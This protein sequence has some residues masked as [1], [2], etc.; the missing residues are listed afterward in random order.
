MQVEEEENNAV[1]GWD[2]GHGNDDDAQDDFVEMDIEAAAE[3]DSES[4]SFSDTCLPEREQ[5]LVNGTS[6]NLLPANG[7]MAANESSIEP[8]AGEDSACVSCICADV[9]GPSN[10]TCPMHQVQLQPETE[11]FD[12]AVDEGVGLPEREGDDSFRP[13]AYCVP[14]CEACTTNQQQ[15]PQVGD[16]EPEVHDHEGI[17]VEE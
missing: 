2:A 14:D 7:V 9:A 3:S 5:G 1:N 11:N 8:S 17:V 12:P 10:H 15:Q 16:V 6:N 4:S 13:L